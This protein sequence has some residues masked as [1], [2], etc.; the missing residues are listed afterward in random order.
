M[1]QYFSTAKFSRAIS[2]PLR[3]TV[4]YFI[5]GALWIL[6]SDKILWMLVNNPASLT[7]ISI[8]KGW[9]FV[10]STSLML[11]VL[12]SRSAAR[13]EL[14]EKEARRAEAEYRRVVDIANII[15]IRR[16]TCGHITLF[17]QF[18]Q[19]F[20]GYD[21]QE[22]LGRNAIGTIVPA[23]EDSGHESEK[24]NLDMGEHPEQYTRTI[25]ENMTKNG[26]RIWVAWTNKPIL[27]PHGMLEGF[28]CIGNDVTA[29]KLTEE[30][31]RETEQR[32]QD[33]LNRAPSAIYIKDRQGRY[34]FVNSHFERLSGFRREQ[35][36]DRTDFDLFPQDVAQQSAR[37]D[38]KA[39]DMQI[40]LETEEIAP[41]DG[42]MH[43]FISAKFPLYDSRGEAYAICGISTDINQRKQAER[44]SNDMVRF[45]HTLLD[46]IPS[47]IFYEDNTGKFLGCNNA[48]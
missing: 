9:F 19:D 4:A 33:I 26:N 25:V 37:N 40:P 27:D 38:E 20:F 7:A 44:K 46:T 36:I 1:K 3:I 11:Y 15:I 30:A 42:E 28:L 22:I 16:D 5:V 17:N 12:I 23:A 2:V 39:F 6:L 45:M 43:T 13:I 35:V 47:P 18:A 34:T 10:G 29:H 41:V 48:F 32:F 21:Q 31:L 14:S 24:I 8:I